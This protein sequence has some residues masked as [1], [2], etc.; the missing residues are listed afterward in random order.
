MNNWALLISP[1]G[2]YSVWLKGTESNSNEDV[3]LCFTIDNEEA[4]RIIDKTG[5]EVEEI[6]F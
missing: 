6:P 1:D 2:T 4:K 5:C 3:S